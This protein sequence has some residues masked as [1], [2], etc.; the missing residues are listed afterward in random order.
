MPVAQAMPESAQPEVEQHE[1]PPVLVRQATILVVDDDPLIAMSTVDMLEDLGHTVIEA[2][3]ADQALKILENG[4]PVDLMLTDHA[5]P[6]MTGMELA[7]IAKDKHPEMPILLA[8]GYTD[9][10]AGQKIDLPRLSK[11]YMQTELQEHIDRLLRAS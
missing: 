7:R 3:S 8:T 2:N 1:E 10:P 9:L 11:P 6:G 4:Q 5:M